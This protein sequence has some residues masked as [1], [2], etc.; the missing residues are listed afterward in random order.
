LKVFRLQSCSKLNNTALEHIAQLAA[1]EV[2]DLSACHRIDDEGFEKLVRCSRLQNL[3]LANTNISS[4]CVSSLLRALQGTLSSINLTRCT[5]LQGSEL[6]AALRSCRR[7][8]LRVARFRGVPAIGVGVL[9]AFEAV[10]SI[11]STLEV[12]DVSDCR[13]IDDDAVLQMLC[14][15]DIPADSGDEAI[16]IPGSSSHQMHLFESLCELNLKGTGVT[17]RGIGVFSLHTPALEHLDVSNCLRVNS[18]C[19][20]TI[21]QSCPR[22]KS[23]CLS[24]CTE[25]T[26]G[27]LD[28]LAPLSQT[29]VK[30][31]LEACPQVS[32][33]GMRALA[34]TAPNLDTL[35]VAFTSVSDAGIVFL[36]A[37][38]SLRVLSL[39]GLV[40]VT[41]NGMRSLSSG[42]SRLRIEN[43][44]LSGCRNICD[45]ACG[46]IEA[47]S[48]LT[49]LSL[50]NCVDVS[51]AGVRGVMA[52]LR[53]LDSLNLRGCSRISESLLCE[54]LEAHALKVLGCDHAA[55]GAVRELKDARKYH[56]TCGLSS[57]AHAIGG[58]SSYRSPSI[59]SPALVGRDSTELQEALLQHQLFLDVIHSHHVTSSLPGG[60]V[61]ST[62]ST[63][64]S[65]STSNTTLSPVTSSLAIALQSDSIPISRSSSS[66]RRRRRRTPEHFPAGTSI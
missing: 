66:R 58:A 8:R 44:N 5:N 57:S 6:G 3:A 17:G 38:R 34:R 27:S 32:N 9:G 26:N 49:R 45:L 63:G 41:W 53:R 64:A 7:L 59:R 65:A 43:L 4:P 36:S 61:S 23:L 33:S 10:D 52:S 2:L 14:F 21:A 47:L 1:L 13:G 60:I 51:E 35:S 12:L 20:D 28:S 46:A 15:A 31:D 16:G 42:T 29:L 24:G 22:L 55:T 19:I 11:R 25:I 62:S 18:D 40:G 54:L 50:H 39:K 56:P 37:M 48:G 30:L